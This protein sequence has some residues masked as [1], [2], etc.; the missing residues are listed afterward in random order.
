MRAAAELGFLASA[1]ALFEP[2]EL[3]EQ[4]APKGH[5]PAGHREQ[6]SRLLLGS[7]DV[8]QAAKIEPEAVEGIRRSQKCCGEWL[9]RVAG[10]EVPQEDPIRSCRNDPATHAVN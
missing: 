5:V 2:S 3:L 10:R 1:V 6:L 7:T 4:R 9:P 8:E